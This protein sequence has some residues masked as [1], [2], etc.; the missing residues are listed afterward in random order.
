MKIRNILKSFVVA[1]LLT[2]GALANDPGN[3]T[4][5]SPKVQQMIEKYNLEVVDFN[6]A[7]AKLSKG[8]INTAKA[9]FVDARPS[10]MFKTATIPS[11]INIPDTD[12]ANY[13]G[14]LKDTPK[15]KEILVFCGG[16]KC[17]K[18]PKVANLLK[19]DGFTNVKLYQAGVPQWSKKSYKEVD[20]VVVKSN[21]AK[22]A[23]VLID[24]RPYKL[25]LKETIPGAISI[26]DTKVEELKG[27]FPVHQNEKIIAFCGGYKCAKSHNIA[28]KLISMGYRDVNVFAGGLPQWK[29]EGLST[30]KSAGTPVAK[31]ETVKATMSKNGA[32]IGLDEG[33]IDGDWLN[34]FIKEDKVPSFIQIVDVT[35]GSEFKNGHIKGAININAEKLSAKELYSKLPKD[36]TIVF[37]CTAGGRSIEAWTKLKEAKL[38]ISE[39]FYFDANVDC[40]GTDCKIEVNEA[41]GI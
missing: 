14:Q 23:A 2:T 8:T 41:L 39:V 36:K 16:W 30:T 29:K 4:K 7:K 31:K 28:N 11:S 1:G 26:P 25:F 19:K 35:D 20:L 9:I 12:Y 6:Y 15:D 18:S 34:S 5:P 10:K 3:L 24:A 38:D 13:V 17:G 32:K 27:R 40:K 37:N 21:Q 33:S 22:N